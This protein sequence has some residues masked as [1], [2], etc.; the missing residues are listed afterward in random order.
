MGLDEFEERRAASHF[1]WSQGRATGLLGD[2]GR[3]QETEEEGGV[4][5]VMSANRR[6]PEVGPDG[7][8]RWHQEETE[9]LGVQESAGVG[10]AEV[11]DL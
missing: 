11:L 6:R 10:A 4:T 1:A 9:A 2:A 8:W 5:P 7:L 3:R